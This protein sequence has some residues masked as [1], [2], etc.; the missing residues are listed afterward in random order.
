VVTRASIGYAPIEING[1]IEAITLPLTNQDNHDLLAI[2]RF[3]N[4]FSSG[5]KIRIRPARTTDELE[6]IY[7]D[8]QVNWG[9]IGVELNKTL[10]IYADTFT[11]DRK[12]IF[13][14]ASEYIDLIIKNI[15]I[16]EALFG[17]NC[18]TIAKN[19]IFFSGIPSFVET[20]GIFFVLP[21]GDVH[22]NTARLIAKDLTDKEARLR[23]EALHSMGYISKLFGLR[24]NKESRLEEVWEGLDKNEAEAIFH[25]V[26]QL[27]G[28]VLTD[29]IQLVEFFPGL[30]ESV[31]INDLAR[32]LVGKDK[33]LFTN[34]LSFLEALKQDLNNVGIIGSAPIFSRIQ[35]AIDLTSIQ[36]KQ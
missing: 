14:Q 18:G 30:I 7:R 24:E 25:F 15:H 28:A 2:D 29:E 5:S 3:G 31:L 17:Y 35:Q 36:L 12:S 10:P 19:V 8:L 9:I 20:M 13:K 33:K 6:Q 1:V 11:A 23:H 26:Y 32:K 22:I 4:Y 27:M 16:I 21:T 34:Y